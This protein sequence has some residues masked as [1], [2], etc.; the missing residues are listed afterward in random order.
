M[1]SRNKRLDVSIN[2]TFQYFKNQSPSLQHFASLTI[3]LLWKRKRTDIRPRTSFLTK[4]VVGRKCFSLENKQLSIHVF[5]GL[6]LI[7]CHV[8]IRILHLVPAPN[9]LFFFFFN[10]MW[11]YEETSLPWPRNLLPYT[12]DRDSW[13]HFLKFPLRI[14]IGVQLSKWKKQN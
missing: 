1:L 7:S 8:H 10:P 2:Q 13:T 5:Q 12:V 14:I 11:N 9:V 6:A 3:S 4:A